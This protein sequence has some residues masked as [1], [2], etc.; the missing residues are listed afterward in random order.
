M[1]L[2]GIHSDAREI[3]NLPGLR[4]ALRLVRRTS[5]PCSISLPVLPR[6]RPKSPSRTSENFEKHVMP[7][8]RRAPQYVTMNVFVNNLIHNLFVVHHLQYHGAVQEGGA[9]IRDACKVYMAAVTRPP[10]Q[11]TYR[12]ALCLGCR[13]LY[14]HNCEFERFYGEPSIGENGTNAFTTF[15]TSPCAPSSAPFFWRFFPFAVFLGLDRQY[16]SAFIY[17]PNASQMRGQKQKPN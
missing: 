15:N 2:L 3:L 17:L 8:L 11:S 7:L 9:D 6:V 14:K 12:P 13:R 4:S 10:E 1:T 5:T 16:D